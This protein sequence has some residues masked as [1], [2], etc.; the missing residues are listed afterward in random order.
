MEAVRKAI[1][2][3]RISLTKDGKINPHVA[4]K[5]WEINSKRKHIQKVNY[6]TP[7]L[8]TESRIML[9]VY[10]AKT[11]KLE[12]EQLNNKLIDIE[13][14][15]KHAAITGKILRERLLSIPIRT[16][17][18][19]MGKLGINSQEARHNIFETLT[20][21]IHASLEALQTDNE[22]SELLGQLPS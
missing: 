19:I 3:K 21:E 16:T 17:P 10:K 5:E 15:K 4:D 22:L 13:I 14:V 12:F 11:A 18:I 9:E 7:P 6:E 8:L 1:R 20:R 2:T